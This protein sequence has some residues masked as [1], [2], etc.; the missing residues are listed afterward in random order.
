METGSGYFLPF[1]ALTHQIPT[2]EGKRI[3]CVR[4]KRSIKRNIELPVAIHEV[5][6]GQRSR[7]LS[8]SDTKTQGVTGKKIKK[9]YIN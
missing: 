4:Q 8:S 9:G 2:L 6:D 5:R 3:H 7:C 1:S